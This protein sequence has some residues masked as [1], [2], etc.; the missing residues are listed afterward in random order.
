MNLLFE[1]RLDIQ[2]VRSGYLATVH[3]THCAPPLEGP[4][5][6][7]T[8]DMVR[9]IDPLRLREI[10]PPEPV[11][12]PEG[13]DERI[14]RYF[15]KHYRTSIWRNPEAGLYSR[16]GESRAE[17]VERCEETLGEQR[18]K[19]VQ[20]IVDVFLRRFLELEQRALAA[21]E[22]DPD[23]AGE[24]AD[25][26]LS[27]IRAVFSNIRERL[28]SR[29]LV[30]AETDLTDADF[31]WKSG[32]DTEG[33]ERLETIRDEFLAQL[34]RARGVLRYNAA[35]LEV[36]EVPVTHSQ[37]DVLSRGFLWN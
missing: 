23:W 22:D 2:D 37:I 31:S 16:P 19:A 8:G 12:W 25:R 3:S 34:N 27:E 32:L 33:R 24:A 21:L 5:L 9:R 13:T 26:R 15:V 1:V 4:E 18:K 29:L 20:S 6:D 11:S 36:Y 30:A 14:V 35:Q 7:W 10:S 17:F 28:S